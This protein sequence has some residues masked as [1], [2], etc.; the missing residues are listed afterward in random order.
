[1]IAQV[2]VVTRRSPPTAGAQWPGHLNGQYNPG[3]SVTLSTHENYSTT[4][5]PFDAVCENIT[6]R[7]LLVSA[8]TRLAVEREPTVENKPSQ[9]RYHNPLPLL[10]PTM[11]W[12]NT[13]YPDTRQV[14]TVTGEISD[15]ATFDADSVPLAYRNRAY[16]A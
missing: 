4:A 15:P 1:M 6:R 9:P 14:Q 5:V 8:Y 12:T 11:L 13:E 7:V 2:K 16:P 10:K 3:D